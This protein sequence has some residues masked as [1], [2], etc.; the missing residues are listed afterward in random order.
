MID[1][2]GFASKLN[3]ELCESF[4][5]R[6]ESENSWAVRTPF[7]YDDGDGLPVFVVRRDH[8]WDITD[9]GMT[10]SHLFF[11]DFKVTPKRLEKIKQLVAKYAGEVSERQAITLSMEDEPSSFEI[12]SFLQMVSQVQGLA[13]TS[14]RKQDSRFATTVGRSVKQ[15]LRKDS[16]DENWSPPALRLET[17]ATYS[18]NLRIS[19]KHGNVAL[20]L[21]GTSE[22]AGV[23]AMAARRFVDI[24]QTLVPVLAF[25]KNGVNSQ[26]VYRFQE[27][28]G[29]DHGIVVEVKV[30]SYDNL[31]AT[32]ESSGVELVEAG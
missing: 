13:H 27:E 21:A 11:D 4:Q 16:Y 17:K 19:A 12:G 24:D 3:S 32:L 10:I 26:A 9:H 7:L 6:Q 18:S 20:F 2:P 15:H 31:F 23:S 28:T 22:R 29:P 5:V 14:S 30:G 1:S 25:H 8:K